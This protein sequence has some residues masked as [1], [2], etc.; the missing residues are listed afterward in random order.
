MTRDEEAGL[1]IE[2]PEAYEHQDVRPAGVFIFLAGLFVALGLTLVFLWWLFGVLA[3][4]RA[5]V[6]PFPALK[7]NQVPPE[8]RLQS[9]PQ[10]EIQQLRAHEDA[11]LE[12]YGWVDKQ[13]GIVRIPIDRAMDLLSERGLPARAGAAAM[14]TVPETGPESGGPQTGQ[15]VPRFNP[16]TPFVPSRP[17]QTTPEAQMK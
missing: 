13:K 3:A 6:G 17:L 12:T 5:A 10:I 8:P 16:S 4:N 9:T 7:P 15:P 1:G 14:P 11:V 2:N